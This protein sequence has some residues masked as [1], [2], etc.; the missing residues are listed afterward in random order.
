MGR[1]KGKTRH[2]GF[3]L[4]ESLIALAI[5]GVIATFTI[6]KI[7]SAQQSSKYNAA[8]KEA[9]GTLP[10]AYQGYYA[11][12]GLSAGTS[13]GSLTQYINYVATDSTST[14]DLWQTGATRACNGF[15]SC[16]R[17]HNRGI[18]LYANSESFAGTSTTNA[19]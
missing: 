18:L 7:L 19:V 16:L 11:Q 13:V 15:Y 12:N 4:A 3:T 8:A 9:A 1:C 5:L 14:I 2:A 6:P 10:A 17:L